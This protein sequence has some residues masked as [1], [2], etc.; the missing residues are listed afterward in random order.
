MPAFPADPLEPAEFLERWLPR[1]FAELPLPEGAEQ[2]DVRV[3]VFLEGPGGGEWVMYLAGGRLE[4]KAEPRHEAGLSV[5]QSVADWRGALWEGRGGVI[6]QGAASLFRPEGRGAAEPAARSLALPALASLAPLRELD[7]LLRL[8]VSGGEGGDWAVGVKLG[9][10]A[11]PEEPTTTVTLS[12]A[13]AA[14]MAS[15][16]LNPLEA[17]MAGRIQLAGDVALM[18]QIQAILMQASQDSGGGATG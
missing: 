13:D 12:A 15:G 10:G 14:A 16:E 9:G 7:G 17:F 1:A 4:V 3:G 18:M 8:V 2:L 11:I 5:V 6:G